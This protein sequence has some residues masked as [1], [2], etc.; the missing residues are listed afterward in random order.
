MLNTNHPDDEQLSS[1]AAGDTDTRDDA[2]LASHVSACDRCAGLVRDLDLL[3]IELS[4][5]PDLVPPRPLRL[6]PAVDVEPVGAVDRL[7]QWARRLFAPALTAGAVLA[8]VGVVGTALPA[9]DG[10]ASSGGA[11]SEGAAASASNDFGR[12]LNSEASSA[13]ESAASAAQEA[14][15]FAS[16]ADESRAASVPDAIDQSASPQAGSAEGGT[17]ALDAEPSADAARD[18]ARDDDA[19]EALQAE[20]SPWPMV[21]FT[22]IAVMIGAALLRWILVPRTG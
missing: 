18:S 5:L 14:L 19:V 3:R 20:R 21:A 15:P 2:A 16:G 1:L 7:G 11:D 8:M 17:A 10:M 9:M 6:L 13:P 12:T 22:G 4:N